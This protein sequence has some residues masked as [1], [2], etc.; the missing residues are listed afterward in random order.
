MNDLANRRYTEQVRT[1]TSTAERGLSTQPMF[2][3]PT[4]FGFPATTALVVENPV[5]T[6]APRLP[7]RPRS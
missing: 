1:A 7:L 5:L 3:A 6:R 2:F 4:P